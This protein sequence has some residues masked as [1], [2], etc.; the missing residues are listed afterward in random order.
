MLPHDVQRSAPQQG[1]GPSQSVELDTESTRFEGQLARLHARHPDA[2][3]VLDRWTTATLAGHQV[4]LPP[5]RGL[6]PATWAAL[7]SIELGK[8]TGA[9]S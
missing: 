1:N 5:A 7:A 4:D 8:A 2:A 6:S 3:A 9:V